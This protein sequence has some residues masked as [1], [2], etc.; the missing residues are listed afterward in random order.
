LKLRVPAAATLDGTPIFLPY[1]ERAGNGALTYLPANDR[2][3]LAWWGGSPWDSRPGV[4][5]AI[6]VAG[7]ASVAEIWA[8]FVTAFPQLAADLGSPP[9]NVLGDTERGA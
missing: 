6:I 1:P 3:I 5:S 9:S 7:R 8:R 4:N 2:S